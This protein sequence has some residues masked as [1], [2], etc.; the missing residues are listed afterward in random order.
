V[1]AL[2]GVVAFGWCAVTSAQE[3]VIKINPSGA[4]LYRVAVVGDGSA[5][6]V[7]NDLDLT[8]YFK[9]LDPAGF[10]ATLTAEPMG[11][12]NIPNWTQVGAQG[13][14]KVRG[15]ECVLFEVGRGER[16]TLSKRTSG[17]MRT[18]AH[19]CANEIVRHF[20]GEDGFFASQI[21]FAQGG[22][23]RVREIYAVDFDGAGS[24][25][26]THMNSLSML[27]SW[28]PGGRD[29]AFL[30]YIFGAP[31]LWIVPGGGGRARRVTKTQDAISGAAFSPDGNRIAVTLSRG[32]NADIYLVGLDGSIQK[33]LT[34]SP[35]IDTSPAWSP[36]G[37]Q[38]AFVSNRLGN[39]QL[40]LMGA[41][42]GGARRLTYQ[43][44]YNQTPR[45]CPRR[46]LPM[47]AF[48]ARDEHLHF[49]VFTVDPRSGQVARVTQNQGD[50]EE[51][52]FA[53]NCRAL[54]YKSSRGGIWMINPN[55]RVEHQIYR[56]AVEAPRW[57]PSQR[58][59]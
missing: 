58:R 1:K 23:S 18:A 3:A 37:S 2:V 33:R 39:P 51:P 50:N 55:T 27:P 10:P 52:S 4:E 59:P 5:K 22:R 53:P 43:G 9:V 41:D 32:G 7:A 19:E 13:V 40:F 16:A 29:V 15:S 30:S 45:W 54:A 12:I 47:L 46:D 6:I 31:D 42:G 34:D 26:L 36:D 48:T 35:G 11:S 56:G 28:A 38:I 57:G 14:A 8:G 24:H 25:A 20:T 44:T 21:T 49:D 17:E